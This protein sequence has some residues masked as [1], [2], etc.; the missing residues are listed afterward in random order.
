MS[1]LETDLHACNTGS[2]ILDQEYV[3]A[4]DF[5]SVKSNISVC[6]QLATISLAGPAADSGHD[7]E[8]SLHFLSRLLRHTYLSKNIQK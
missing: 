2:E 4:L 7:S 6:R 5:A 8:S 1:S 3:D